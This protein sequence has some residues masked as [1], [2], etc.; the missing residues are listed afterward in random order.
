MW[1]TFKTTL[2]DSVEL[3]SV[4]ALGGCCRLIQNRWLF[5][6]VTFSAHVSECITASKVP[7]LDR[8]WSWFEASNTDVFPCWTGD[9]ALRKPKLENIQPQLKLTHHMLCPA[10]SKTIHCD[11]MNVYYSW[12]VFSNS[13]IPAEELP[14][15]RTIFPWSPFSETF[16]LVERYNSGCELC[17]P[18]FLVL[19]RWARRR[20]WKTT[21]RRRRRALAWTL[22]VSSSSPCWWC[23]CCS[24]FTAPGWP[25]PPTP[26]PASCWLRTD[27][28]GESWGF[29]IHA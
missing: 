21:S 19:C 8:E 11:D 27:R 1:E 24:L 12:D 17:S 5:F 4:Y 25:A 7:F 22:R 28:E 15:P 2:T 14:W 10:F 29:C 20:K 13:G 9:L 18:L 6:W 23:W 26:V 16:P 3:L